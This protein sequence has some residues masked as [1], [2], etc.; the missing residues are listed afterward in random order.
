MYPATES[1]SSDAAPRGDKVEWYVRK[2]RL[3]AAESEAQG[4]ATQLE[5]PAARGKWLVF[6][7]VV[8]VGLSAVLAFATLVVTR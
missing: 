8:A 4:T 3:E 6:A 5:V 2:F 1:V 7:A